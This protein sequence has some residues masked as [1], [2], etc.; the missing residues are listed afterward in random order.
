MTSVRRLVGSWVSAASSRPSFSALRLTC[1][2]RPGPPYRL[3]TTHGFAHVLTRRRDGVGR[4]RA[5]RRLL[6][7]G[8]WFAQASDILAALEIEAVR[9]AVRL[10]HSQVT[11]AHLVLAVLS[12]DEQMAFDGGELPES[13]ALANAPF[14]GEFNITLQAAITM[15][16]DSGEAGVL[17]DARPER[18]RALRSRIGNPTW[19]RPSGDFGCSPHARRR[20]RTPMLAGVDDLRP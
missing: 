16:W 4:W 2:R 12:F 10:A 20:R 9:Q 15:M 3:W 5:E 11:S 17:P 19:S 18:R 14:L 6:R 13:Q 8:S 1:F 7:S